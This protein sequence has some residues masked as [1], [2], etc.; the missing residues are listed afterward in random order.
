M[1]SYEHLPPVFSTLTPLK[2]RCLNSGP[3]QSLCGIPRLSSLLHLDLWLLTI[4][5]N[6][7]YYGSLSL[8][9]RA[10]RDMK[11]RD[12]LFSLFIFLPL[13]TVSIKMIF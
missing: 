12:I 3:T 10:K 4:Y 8:K 6:R 2:S 13:V 7:V 1:G 9:K 5:V 11:L